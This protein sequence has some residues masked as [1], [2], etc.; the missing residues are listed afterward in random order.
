M[1][2]YV[3]GLLVDRESETVILVKK[4][5]DSIYGGHWNGVA[6]KVEC[7]DEGYAEA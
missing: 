3:A 4:R 5:D 6:G 1:I 7:F 2:E